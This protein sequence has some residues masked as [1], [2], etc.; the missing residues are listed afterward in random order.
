MGYLSAYY[1]GS[2]SAYEYEYSYTGNWDPNGNGVPN[3]DMISYIEANF[4]T[5]SISNG[6]DVYYHL[7]GGAGNYIVAAIHVPNSTVGHAVI[8]QG[9]N[10]NGT[11]YS[12][13]PSNGNA[14]LSE[15]DASSI[16]TNSMIGVCGL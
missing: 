11:Y 1:G 3:S 14:F 12:V 2:C 6:T 7:N 10:S 5:S 13:D 8:I 15:I 16:Y 9:Q 4:T